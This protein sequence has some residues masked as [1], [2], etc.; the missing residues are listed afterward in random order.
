MTFVRAGDLH[1]AAKTGNL[2]AV[3][4]LVSGGADIYA[5][6]EKREHTAALGR[7][8]MPGFYFGNIFLKLF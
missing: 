2:D 6:D 4:T 8:E 5:T 1:E 7:I 3:T